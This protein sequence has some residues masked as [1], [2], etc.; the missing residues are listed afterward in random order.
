[1]FTG[2][3]EEIGRVRRLEPRPEGA[4]IAIE[5]KRVLEETKIGDSIAT[6]GVCLTVVTMDGESFTAN[7]MAETL[8]MTNLGDL[9]PGDPVNLERAMSLKGRLGGHLVAGHVDGLARIT[10]KRREGDSLWLDRG[11]VAL[12]GTS[13]TVARRHATGLSV[14]LIPVTQEETVLSRKSLGQTVNV[15]VDMI[16]KYVEQLLTPQKASGI[17]MNFLKQHGF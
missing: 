5:A 1:M 2:I 11:S 12:D 15:E 16:G 7:V 10:G 17:D 9:S 14:S 4:R 8:R 6:N 13:L 3:I